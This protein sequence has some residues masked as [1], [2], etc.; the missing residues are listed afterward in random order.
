MSE[1]STGI[2]MPWGVYSFGLGPSG[3]GKIVS[4][5]KTNLRIR[6]SEEQYPHSSS[7]DPNYVKRFA[8]LEE[9]VEHYIENHQGFDI[10]CNPLNPNEVRGLA[11][12]RFPSQYENKNKD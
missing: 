12:R 11:R 4:D 3:F 7:W 8:T 5:N 9:A 2:E 10:R 1:E 6:H